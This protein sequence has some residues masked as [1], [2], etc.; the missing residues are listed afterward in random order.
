MKSAV[1]TSG[2]F[3]FIAFT[4]F[5]L[6][7]FKI[8]AQTPDTDNGVYLISDAQGLKWFADYISENESSIDARLTSDID[9]SSICSQSSESWTPIG[10]YSCPYSGTFDGNGYTISGLYINDIGTDSNYCGLFGFLSGMVKNLSVEGNVISASGA[11]GGI[12]GCNSGTVENSLFTGYTEGSTCSGGIAA[13]NQSS[14]L[15]QNC[16]TVMTDENIVI[17]TPIALNMN[18][19]IKNCY[20]NEELGDD[21]NSKTTSMPLDSFYS[22][23]VC[24]L[25]NGSQE[26]IIW[27]QNIDNSKDN[28]LPVP[29]DKYGTVYKTSV[30][31][32]EEIYYSNFNMIHH[33]FTDGICENCSV[34]R[35]S[36]DYANLLLNQSIDMK[37]YITVN[38][39]SLLSSNIIFNYSFASDSLDMS[40]RCE[41]ET[42]GTYTATVPCQVTQM[43][44]LIYTKAYA[45]SNDEIIYTENNAT[46]YSVLKYSEHILSDQTNVYG[47]SCKKLILNI[48]RYGCES[49]QYFYNDSSFKTEVMNN[50]S[51][52]FDSFGISV[53]VVQ[54][55]DMSEYKEVLTDPSADIRSAYLTL[56]SKVCLN[57]KVNSALSGI[58][59]KFEDVKT[60]EVRIIPMSGENEIYTAQIQDISAENIFNDFKMTVIDYNGNKISNTIGYNIENYI[61]TIVN[62][63]DSQINKANNI[64]LALLGYGKAVTEYCNE[65][66]QERI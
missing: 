41:K 23:E 47:D 55:P 10:S 25:L 52:Y 20:Y 60:G 11:A 63:S 56:N 7:N 19:R 29:S 1:R 27:H 12:A 6:Y 45:E 13:E 58:S 28:T 50:F 42:D 39:P 59:L 32:S 17:S 3:I 37:Y 36:T 46:E 18:G 40:V 53:P 51:E 24:Y 65:L 66:L 2:I 48:L 30:C 5:I 14:G 35:I 61:Y 44:Q 4:V 34:K 16:C 57:I 8:T 54:N 64:S 33:Q 38:D 31:G 43:G 49:Q 15:I 9:L 26:N 21:G 62:S 22:G